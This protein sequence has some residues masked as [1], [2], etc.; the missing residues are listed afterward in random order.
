MKYY[1]WNKEKNDLLKIERDISFE[2]VVIAIESG[3]LLEIVKHPNSRKYPN[4]KIYLVNID[5]YVYLAP[6]VEDEEK[7]FLK[8]I[9]PSKKATRK[10][11]FKGGD[12]K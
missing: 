3:G 12:T 9:I 4:Q 1:D 7:I 5:N 6:F 10:Y 2:Q 8:T 11:L